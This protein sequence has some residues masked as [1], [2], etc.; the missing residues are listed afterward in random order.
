MRLTRGRVWV[1]VANQVD[2]T[3]ST[4][5]RRR[6]GLTC[7]EKGIA[8]KPLNRVAGVIMATGLAFGGAGQAVAATTA[9]PSPH[10]VEVGAQTSTSPG[11]LAS[12]A[13]RHAAAADGTATAP[14]GNDTVN[15][16]VV[17]LVIEALK[18]A[19]KPIYDAAVHFVRQGWHAFQGW[20][21]GLPWWIKGPVEWAAGG[22]AWEVFV[23][24]C[25]HLGIRW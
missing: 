11:I 9:V 2:L 8:M 21:S 24:I 4:A 18:R 23:A 13:A 17:R 25:N 19:G 1:E 6:T 5:R 22:G 10:I 20:W 12:S 7:I 14:N 3:T 16:P 15:S